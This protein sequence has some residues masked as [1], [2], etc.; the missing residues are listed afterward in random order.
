MEKIG[1]INN[2]PCYWLPSHKAEGIEFPCSYM[3]IITDGNVDLKVLEN[4]LTKEVVALV[5]V[6]HDLEE[7]LKTLGK[8]DIL[9]TAALTY[10]EGLKLGSYLEGRDA[11]L[12]VLS[13]EKEKIKNYLKEL[14]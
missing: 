7:P 8:K 4:R 2:L 13:K 1:T 14:N 10:E 12:V 5:M 6:C 11:C 9:I 3:T